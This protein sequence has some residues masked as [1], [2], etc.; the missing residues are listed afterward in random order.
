VEWD[1]SAI[2]FLLERGFTIDL[3]ARPLRRA[4]ERYLL[5]PL[6]NTLVNRQFP[7]GDQFL[8]IRRKGE[9]LLVEFVDP[10]ANTEEKSFESSPVS[11]SDIGAGRRLE[12]IILCPDPSPETTASLNSRF[13]EIR[14]RMTTEA[15]NQKKATAW[16]AM[17]EPGFWEL[18]ERFR[19]LGLVEY[20]DRMDTALETA[21]SLLKR[22]LSFS[23]RPGK[24]LPSDLV[25][26]LAQ[27]LY[28]LDR[29]CQGIE[30]ELPLEAFL[31]IEVGKDVGSRGSPGLELASKLRHMYEG[32]AKARRMTWQVLE[33]SELA[34]DD[35]CYFLMAVSGLGVYPILAAENGL[36]I[37]EVPENEGKSFRRGLVRVRVVPQPPEPV[38]TGLSELRSQALQSL[39]VGVSDRPEIVRRYRAQPS[40]VVRDNVG[41]WRTGRLDLVL[42]GD[43][44]LMCDRDP[45][46]DGTP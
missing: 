36:H 17:N 2:E 5:S 21:G 28:L 43:F 20:L 10:D 30:H 24:R 18:P 16:A 14:E 4:V 45:E 1:D 22:L 40:P 38:N 13:E 35:G 9:Q 44:D 25:R 39:A 23:G 34:T 31:S 6:A 8:F 41:G 7:E 27:Q 33:A 12:E 46:A 32:W 37:F 26:Q 29:A 11:R 3:G 15:W 42:Q 19:T